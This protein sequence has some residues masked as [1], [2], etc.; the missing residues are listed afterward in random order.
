M[1]D[2]VF[3]RESSEKDAGAVFDP[4]G[5]VVSGLTPVYDAARRMAREHPTLLLTLIYVALTAIGL[6]YDW[7]FF[8][9]FRINILDY[10]E[11]SDFLLAA[12]RRPLVILLCLLPLVILAM[13]RQIRR[14]ARQKSNRYDQFVKRST[15]LRIA[16]PGLTIASYGLFVFIYAVLFMQLYAA[17]VA[18]RVKSGHGLQVTVERTT[19]LNPEEKPILL[20]TT[21]KYVFL[22]YRGRKETEIVP[23]GAV[24]RVTVDSRRRREREADSARLQDTITVDSTDAFSR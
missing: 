8:R 5:G 6:I 15:V 22:Y 2:P 13:G 14:W 19:G 10:S 7:W 24:S 4:I 9:Y 3:E 21:S 20:G 12:I 1:T 18:K 23:V 16:N 11:T 17:F